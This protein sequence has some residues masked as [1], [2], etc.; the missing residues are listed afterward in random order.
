MI[1]IILLLASIFL[2][3]CANMGRRQ[4]YEPNENHKEWVVDHTLSKD[5]SYNRAITWIAVHFNSA[6]D[7]IQL[8]DKETGTIVVKALA[9][10]TNVAYPANIRYTF[11]LKTKDNKAKFTFDLGGIV[12]TS[13]YPEDPNGAPSESEMPAIIGNM[14]GIKNSIVAEWAKQKSA[15]DF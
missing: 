4:G 7:V 11:Q 5:E 6:N 3:G 13:D 10:W 9:P 8:K 14:E 1:R 15:D 12:G 2:F